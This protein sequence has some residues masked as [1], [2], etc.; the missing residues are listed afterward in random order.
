MPG[1]GLTRFG[2]RYWRVGA[3]RA[4]LDPAA[5]L[6]YFALS[7][8]TCPGSTLF[9]IAH[10]DGRQAATSGLFDSEVLGG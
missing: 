7:M 1:I 5:T 9:V 2:T 6:C 10:D 3:V 8:A 4:F